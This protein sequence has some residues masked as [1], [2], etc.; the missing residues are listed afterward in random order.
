MPLHYARKAYRFWNGYELPQIVSYDY[1]QRE[2]KSLW[3]LA[4]QGIALQ[5]QLRVSIGYVP[6]VL[7]LKK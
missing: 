6:K 7:L 5:R 4:H 1:Y 2:F 3:V